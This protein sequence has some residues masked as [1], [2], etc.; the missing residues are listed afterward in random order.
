MT[1]LIPI[2]DTPETEGIFE[3]CRQNAKYLEHI[4]GMPVYDPVIRSAEDDGFVG[5]YPYVLIDNS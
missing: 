5:Y 1:R 2:V 4:H 3:Y